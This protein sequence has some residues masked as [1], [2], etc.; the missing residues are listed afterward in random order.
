M[1]LLSNGLKIFLA[2][3]LMLF[4]HRLVAEAV[5]FNSGMDETIHFNLLLYIPSIS[6]IIV[7]FI[8]VLIALF[9]YRN[10]NWK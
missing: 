2:G 10:E 8:I 7:G 5:R 9:K 1:N 4:L 6:F 3:S